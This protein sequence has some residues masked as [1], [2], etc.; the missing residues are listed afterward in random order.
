MSSKEGKRLLLSLLGLPLV[1]RIRCTGIRDKAP[2]SGLYWN[3]LLCIGTQLKLLLRTRG[4]VTSFMMMKMMMMMGESVNQ[5]TGG[6]IIVYNK[7]IIISLILI[8]N[9]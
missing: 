7:I 5:A 4:M 3:L 8:P 1:D 6:N 2:H 9:D